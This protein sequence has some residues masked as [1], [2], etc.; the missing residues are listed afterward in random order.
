[1]EAMMLKSGDFL[2]KAGMGRAVLSGLLLAVAQAATVQAQ[3]LGSADAPPAPRHRPAGLLNENN[4]TSTGETVPRP[5]VSQGAPQSGLD[6]DI[7][8]EDNLVEQSICSNCN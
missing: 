4:L 1:M 8:Q 3:P 5:N 7:E 2:L 6:R